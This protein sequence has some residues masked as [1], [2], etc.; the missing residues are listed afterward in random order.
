M[1]EKNYQLLADA[2]I[3]RAVKDYRRAKMPEDRNEIERFFLSDW[4][5]TLANADS[6][7]LMDRLEQERVSK[8][9]KERG[10]RY[11]GV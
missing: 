6:R 4:F 11:V 5:A 9:S 1:Y 10:G 7:V 8:I 2:I 3:K